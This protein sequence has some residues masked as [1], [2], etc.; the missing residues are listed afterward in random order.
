MNRRTFLKGSAAALATGVGSGSASAL[1]PHPAK[2]RVQGANDRVRLGYIGT[3]RMGRSNMRAQL[4]TGRSEIVALCEVYQPNLAKTLEYLEQEHPEV[5]TPQSYTDFRHL[6]DRQ[7]ID[8]VVISTPDHWHAAQTVM[9]C[10]AG[11]DVYV[12]KPL[13]TSVVEGRRMVQ[14]ARET[15][16]IVQ[17]GTMQRSA[18]HFQRAVEIVRSG[19]LGKISFVR[20]WNMSNEYP[21]GFG[22]SVGGPPP[23]DLDWEM[24]LGPAPKVAF[25]SNRFGVA[26]D[27]FSTFRY[28]WDYAGGMLTDWGVHLIDIVLWAMQEDAPRSVNTAGGKYAITDN[29][30]TPDTLLTTFEF[31]DWVLTYTNQVLNGFGFADRGY[32]ILF[33]GT[34]ATLFVDRSGYELTP[35][36]EREED[37]EI[38]SRPRTPSIKGRS[39]SGGNVEHHENWLD[40][41]ASREEPICDVDIGHR[42]TVLPHLGNIAYRTRSCIEWDASTERCGDN[43]AA[44]QLLGR[45]YRAPWT[46]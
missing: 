11:K 6:L 34:D 40:C 46:L 8:A 23:A 38:E 20:T 21:D 10:Q 32:G 7:D 9:A 43:A 29:R 16:R 5:T 19:V 41:L 18:E 42:S 35:E 27:R 30:E 22:P 33:H 15:G 1:R 14:V 4:A 28:F 12:E 26:D 31:D 36:Y 13:A 37:E 45:P 44:N 17:V 25:D 3:G 24:W 2:A 39:T